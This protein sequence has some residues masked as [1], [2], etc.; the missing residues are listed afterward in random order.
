MRVLSVA[1]RHTNGDDEI[2]KV[3]EDIFKNDGTYVAEHPL[4]RNW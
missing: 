4:K 2:Q 3:A 1:G